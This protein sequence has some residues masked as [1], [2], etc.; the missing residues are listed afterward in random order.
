MSR[1]YRNCEHYDA[2]GRPLHRHGT[3]TAYLRDACR[4]FECTEANRREQAK[5]NREKAYGR[6]DNGRVDATPVREH[7]EVL[8]LAGISLNQV[9]SITGAGRTSLSKISGRYS[10]GTPPQAQCL[11][12]THDA[13]LALEP[14][15]IRYAHPRRP[16]DGTGTSR[17]LQA[18]MAI[19]WNQKDL[20]ARLGRSAQN[21]TILVYGGAKVEA[22]TVRAVRALYDDLWDQ[23]RTGT[24]AAKMARTIAEKNGWVPP[25]A[26]DEEDLDDPTK[27]PA[28]VGSHTGAGAHPYVRYAEVEFLLDGGLGFAEVLAR[29]GIRDLETLRLGMVRR[30]R[31]DLADGFLRQNQQNPITPFTLSA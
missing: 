22:E 15:P 17:R 31:P 19:G 4:C 2:E 24:K 29:T 11:R 12:R 16:L 8:R 25:L 14:D 18:L 30:G 3:R 28:S 27:R 21:F 1:P 6:Y 9:A 23:P 5:R 26:W 10:P 7:L 13:V 20:S